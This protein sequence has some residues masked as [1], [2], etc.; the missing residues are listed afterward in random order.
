MD[1]LEKGVEV[2]EPGGSVEWGGEVRC[3]SGERMQGLKPQQASD[4]GS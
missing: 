4:P 3:A 2:L 1:A